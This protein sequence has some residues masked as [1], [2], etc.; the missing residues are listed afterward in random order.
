MCVEQGNLDAIPYREGLSLFSW[1]GIAS[2]PCDNHAWRPVRISCDA[3]NCM[4]RICL[5]LRTQTD[6]QAHEQIYIQIDIDIDVHTVTFFSTNRATVPTVTQ[7][8][9][10]QQVER[11]PSPNSP[12]LSR[13]RHENLPRRVVL[14]QRLRALWTW[15]EGG[16][17]CHCR[18]GSCG[19]LCPCCR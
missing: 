16:C 17:A 7:R 2:V 13:P 18:W 14:M 19:C 6:R 9:P 5:S 15:P 1:G 11:K 12:L 3:V 8:G 4:H 10:L